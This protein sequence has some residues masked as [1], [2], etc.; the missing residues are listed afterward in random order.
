MIFSFDKPFKTAHFLSPGY[1]SPSKRKCQ[2]ADRCLS[3]IP[4][5][6]KPSPG[7]V[8]E[9]NEHRRGGAVPLPLAVH[10]E[11]M[12]V[13]GWKCP[14]I[15]VG[16]GVLL[17]CPAETAPDEAGLFLADRCHSLRQSTSY[18]APFSA[19][20]KFR[21]YLGFSSPHKAGFAGTPF[22]IRHRRRSGRSPRRPVKPSP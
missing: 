6:Q 7:G 10:T 5:P 16:A 18:K 8:A 13:Y 2:V 21:L 17:R 15:S 4:P 1:C 9:R 19:S 11:E 3:A 22:L 20:G 12:S 14:Y